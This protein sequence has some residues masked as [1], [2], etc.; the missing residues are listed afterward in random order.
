MRFFSFLIK[1][2]SVILIFVKFSIVANA[3]NLI[4]GEIIKDRILDYLNKNNINAEPLLNS[5]R[6]FRKCRE[7]IKIENM[8]KNFS[9]LKIYC[10]DKDGWRLAVRIKKNISKKTIIKKSFKEN[11]LGESYKTDFNELKQNEVFFVNYVTLNKSLKKGDII[12]KSDL[13]IIKSNKIKATNFFS[14]KKDVI[15]RKLNQNLGINKIIKAR[16][17]EINWEIKKNEEVI[18]AN[19]IGPVQVFTKGIALM[20]AQLG[21]TARILNV[22]SGKEIE[23]I[24][25][26]NKNIVVFSKN[27]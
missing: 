10:P 25:N 16:H 15:G 5:N 20:N 23:G 14:D 12:L 2:I 4:K 17:L 26:K 22:S 19:L 21:E 27:F 6:F 3:N 13:K 11:K 1:V 7:E 9:T 24:V 18:I 8:Y